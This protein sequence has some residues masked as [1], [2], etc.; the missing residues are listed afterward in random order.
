MRIPSFLRATTLALALLV[1]GVSL[2]IAFASDENLA[3]QS[4]S[5]QPQTSN[6]GPYDGADSEAAKRAFY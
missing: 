2:G 1:T 5:G 3:A 4:Q 6:T